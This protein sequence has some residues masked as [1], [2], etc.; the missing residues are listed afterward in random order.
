[1]PGVW[2]RLYGSCMARINGGVAQYLQKLTKLPPLA[3]RRHQAV[4]AAC[5]GGRTSRFES[6]PRWRAWCIAPNPF[7]KWL[8]GSKRCRSLPTRTE[9]RR[10]S[11]LGE[12]RLPRMP[13]AMPCRTAASRAQPTTAAWSACL[14]Q[15]FP[16][17]AQLGAG[18]AT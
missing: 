7:V 14:R 3:A 1:M 9:L 13:A 15:V 16:H 8:L 2:R 11:R 5:H 12:N 17:L 18:D 6:L 4:E 10:Q